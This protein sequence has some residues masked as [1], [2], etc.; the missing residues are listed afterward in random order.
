MLFRVHVCKTTFLRMICYYYWIFVSKL[1]SG[2]VT[3]FEN[4]TGKEVA[5]AQL[6]QYPP[7]PLPNNS[8]VHYPHVCSYCPVSFCVLILSSVLLCAH[9]VQYPFV[10]AYCL[11]SLCLLILSIILMCAHIVQCPFVCSYCSVSFCV[12]LLSSILM[13]A[14][15]VQRPYVCSY[16]PVSSSSSS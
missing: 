12:R 9:I 13:C 5:C 2:I 15:I 10:C 16:C 7:P 11:V 3:L 4:E 14:H 8:I 6:H 1:D